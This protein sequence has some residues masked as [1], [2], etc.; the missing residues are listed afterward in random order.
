[1][2]VV[3]HVPVNQ[4]LMYGTKTRVALRGLI[5]FVGLVLLISSATLLV[6]GSSHV[7]TNQTADATAV[8]PGERISFT[9][10]MDATD[11]NAPGLNVTLPEGWTVVDEESTAEE[12][13][14]SAIEWVWLSGGEKTVE[15]TV[16]VPGDATDGEYEVIANGS[17]I[18]PDTG[19]LVFDVDATQVTVSGDET[20]GP[21]TDVRLDPTSETTDGSGE[22]A[23][24][25][26]VENATGGVGAH[27]TT[28]SVADPDVA[29]ITNVTLRGDPGQSAVDIAANNSSVTI[30]AALM[31][32][33]DSG[34]VTIATITVEANSSG[35]TG[36][37]LDVSALG[38]ETGSPYEVTD[39][40]GAT[41]TVRD[42]PRIG[43][44]PNLPTDQNGDG[45]YRDING[46]NSFD[47]VDVQAM[48]A[49]RDDPAL[50]NNPQ[51]FDFNDDGKVDIVDVQRLF[52]EVTA[53]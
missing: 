35:T 44:Y 10:S 11:M 50:T 42:V 33:D 16:E 24:D 30:D 47:I 51:Y 4:I 36:V 5:V 41:L 14:D 29:A 28:V 6:P 43:S 25:V 40:S 39:A 22:T 18:D 53:D 15:Y 17:G 3:G 34:V 13:R 26:L 2:I 37:G 21:S 52:A 12:F 20:S 49:N 32:T 8:Q 7:S 23:F 27:T 19:E 1:M 46:D 48:F 9:V 38:N 45:L 31:D